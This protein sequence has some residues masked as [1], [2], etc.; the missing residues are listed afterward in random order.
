ML[1]LLTNRQ[2]SN[3]ERGYVF[4]KTDESNGWEKKWCIFEDS[5]IRYADYP[6]SPEN[7]FQRVSMDRVVNLCADVS[8][9]PFCHHAVIV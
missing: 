5:E 4:I 2:N 1:Y 7:D 8:I 3:A 9:S 6:T